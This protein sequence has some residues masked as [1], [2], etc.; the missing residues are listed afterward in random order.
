MNMDKSLI[1]LAL[2]ALREQVVDSGETPHSVHTTLK[3][4]RIDKQID[5]IKSYTN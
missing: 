5:L 2:E 3:L 1:I 4:M